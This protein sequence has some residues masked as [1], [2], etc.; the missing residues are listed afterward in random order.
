MWPVVGS[1]LAGC[2]VVSDQWF[3][4]GRLLPLSSEYAEQVKEEV[5]EV[6]IK[7]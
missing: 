5:D 4:V 1:E 7:V 3:W 2:R 6:E